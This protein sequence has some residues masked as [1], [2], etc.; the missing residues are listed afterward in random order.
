MTLLETAQERSSVTRN[1]EQCVCTS[2]AVRRSRCCEADTPLQAWNTLWWRRWLRLSGYWTWIMLHTRTTTVLVS[3][4]QHKDF[5]HFSM[6]DVFPD[7]NHNK[8]TEL[9]K[10]KQNKKQERL[11]F[12]QTWPACVGTSASQLLA[13]NSSLSRPEKRIFG[14]AVERSYPLVFGCTSP[15]K[16]ENNAKKKMVKFHGFTNRNHF[17]DSKGLLRAEF[18][19]ASTHNKKIQSHIS[20]KTPKSH[21]PYL[22]FSGSRPSFAI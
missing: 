1:A 17:I 3:C 6:Q 19:N 20:T 5:T 4:I 18:K 16:R 10:T 22:V 2:Y 9:S 12:S 15:M 7:H 14:T 11:T 21:D 13:R 8:H